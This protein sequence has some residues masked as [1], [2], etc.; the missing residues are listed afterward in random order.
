VT[1]GILTLLRRL[2][3]VTQTILTAPA[4]L[5]EEFNLSHSTP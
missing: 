3:A 4:L 1:T 2:L 5:I